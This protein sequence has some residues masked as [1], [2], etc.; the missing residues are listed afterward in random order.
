MYQGLVGVSFAG[1]PACSRAEGLLCVINCDRIRKGLDV[2]GV[3]ANHLTAAEVLLP[4]LCL[5]AFKIISC[6]EKLQCISRLSQTFSRFSATLFQLGYVPPR[7]LWP[8]QRSTATRVLVQCKNGAVFSLAIPESDR[9]PRSLHELPRKMVRLVKKNSH[10][11]SQ[12]HRD[13]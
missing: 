5:P 9:I 2:S 10:F 8:Q 13:F 7:S 3:P 1:L 6:R 4:F 12:F 11:K